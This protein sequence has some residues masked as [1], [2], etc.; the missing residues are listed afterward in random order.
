VAGVPGD[1]RRRATFGAVVGAGYVGVKGVQGVGAGVKDL[2][3][4][5][6][7]LVGAGVVAYMVLKK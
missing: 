2:F 1:G 6:V 3:S 5:P 7:V 4:H